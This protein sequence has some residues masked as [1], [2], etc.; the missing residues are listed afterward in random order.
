[1]DELIKAT[2]WNDIPRMAKCVDHDQES[3][4]GPETCD[5]N[6]REL[7][8]GKT[9]LM[10]AT[11]LGKKEAAKWLLDNGADVA[12]YDKKGWMT[13]VH[14]AVVNNRTD[15][16]KWI[17]EAV[18]AARDAEDWYCPLSQHNGD[19]DTPLHLAVT[20]SRK[21]LKLAKILVDGGARVD[22]MNREGK[23]PVHLAEAQ[24]YTEMVE[25]LRDRREP[26]ERLDE[27]KSLLVDAYER[28]SDY[29]T[30]A[31]TGL[32]ERLKMRVAMEIS[33]LQEEI[34][35]VEALLNV[36][37]GAHGKSCIADLRRL[38]E[39]KAGLDEELRLQSTYAN[40]SY[41]KLRRSYQI[42]LEKIRQ[43]NKDRMDALQ[44]EIS[45]L[46]ATINAAES[47]DAPQAQPQGRARGT[48]PA[49]SSSAGARRQSSRRRSG[50]DGGS[51]DRKK[52]R[53][54]T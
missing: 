13:A 39:C 40:F 34:V 26:R 41:D 46:E 4:E 29:E 30:R 28:R 49:G 6:C 9:A 38:G 31:D 54:A 35:E 45:E 50:T 16:L 52:R 51:G 42:K 17:V 2:I 5:I 25:L 37:A 14:Y 19:G 10:I 36:G 15:I 24:G 7:K 33:A 20:S 43:W 32:K 22:A 27:A 44:K 18:T 23:K 47:A 12:L 53:R 1:M 11:E 21:G 3:D 8:T 48:A